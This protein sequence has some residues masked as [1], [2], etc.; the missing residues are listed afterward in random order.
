MKTLNKN[1]DSIFTPIEAYFIGKD[2]F[3]SRT[4]LNRGRVADSAKKNKKN[5]SM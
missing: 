3:S 1:S 5:L 2:Y 4:K